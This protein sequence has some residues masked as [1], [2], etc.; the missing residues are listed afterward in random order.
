MA[1]HGQFKTLLGFISVCAAVLTMASTPV[2]SE[3]IGSVDTKFNLLSPDDSIE[4]EAFADPK[5]HGIVCYISRARRGG[6][7]GV[8]RDCGRHVRC[9]D[10]MRSGRADNVARK[11][12]T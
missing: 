1:L 8:P 12:R 4:V 5:V 11:A 6:Y 2:G 9:L 3:E 7:K 10:R